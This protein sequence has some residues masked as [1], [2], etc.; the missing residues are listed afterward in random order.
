M[1]RYWLMKSEP[2][3]FSIDDL[4]RA[5]DEHHPLGRR[6]Q[7]PGA[8][9]PA[10]RHRRRRRRALLPL[11]RGSPGGR[12]HR[13]GRPRRL[14][15]SDAVRSAR[16]PL[17]PRQLARRPALVRRRH[18]VRSEVRARGHAG[19]AARRARA[20]G[21]GAAAPRQP[22]VGAAGDRRRVEADPQDGRARHDRADARR[23][24]TASITS[25][26][27][28]A[29]SPRWKRSTAAC[30]GLPV[31]RRWPGEDG[32]RS[33]WLDLGGGG[34]LALERVAGGRPQHATAGTPTSPAFTCVALAITRGERDAWEAHLTAAGVA[35]AHRTDVHA[36]RTRSRRQPRRPVALARRARRAACRGA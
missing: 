12:R 6:A 26:S 28:S 7:L 9:L 23:V 18:Q 31:L 36:L 14:S 29:I 3:V 24:R 27:R 5:K 11:E 35:V 25:P 13:E 2:S 10:Q 16:R 33:I 15:R 8:Q 30:C 1:A 34:F 32:E 22:P 20:G 4:A 19:R 21:D 17:R